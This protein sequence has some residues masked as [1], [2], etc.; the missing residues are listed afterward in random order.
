MYLGECSILIVY[1]A[2]ENTEHDENDG[3]CV[4]R[5]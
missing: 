1:A 5:Y 3:P 4:C 2:R